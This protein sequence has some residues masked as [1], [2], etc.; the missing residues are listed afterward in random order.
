MQILQTLIAYTLNPS[1]LALDDPLPDQRRPRFV[2]EGGAAGIPGEVR[3]IYLPRRNICNWTGP[4]VQNLE[5]D[6][7][8]HAYYFDPVTGPRFDQGVVKAQWKPGGKNAQPVEFK[9]NVPSP[10]DWV[11]VIERVRQ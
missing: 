10:Q 2:G 4:A 8:W 7:D 9:H 1:R 6:V 5:P 3:F 11:L